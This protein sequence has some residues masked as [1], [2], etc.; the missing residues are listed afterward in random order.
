M[1]HKV[2]YDIIEI[3]VIVLMTVVCR[4][5][6][7]W[8][9][10]KLGAERT[11]QIEEWASRFV[12]AAESTIKGEKK[13]AERREVVMKLIS[14]KAQELGLDLSE[15]DIR[16]LLETAWMTMT[17]EQAITGTT[18]KKEAEDGAERN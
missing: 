5:F 4:Y 10:G 13:G 15:D 17:Q 11:E 3:L 2:L 16:A 1:D 8:A 7:P 14:D 6:V 12:R 18:T 9:K